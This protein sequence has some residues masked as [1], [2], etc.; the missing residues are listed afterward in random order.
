MAGVESELTKWAV[1]VISAMPTLQSVIAVLV[2]L[3][4]ALPLL[5]TGWKEFKARSP[6]PEH[7]PS[8]PALEPWL[9]SAL[10]K[11][12]MEV[13]LIREETRDL[14]PM[15]EALTRAVEMLTTKADGLDKIIRLR[16]K[17][18]RDNAGKK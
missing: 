13:Q 4:L 2:I 12:D 15:V 9:V 3:A 1:S 6:G 8:V 5:R 14:A 18:A 10:T 16:A 11:I 17:R 7:A